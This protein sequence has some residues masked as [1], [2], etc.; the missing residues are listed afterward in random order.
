MSLL[1]VIFGIAAH[2]FSLIRSFGILV[3][4]ASALDA[5]P[6]CVSPPHLTSKHGNFQSHAGLT[7]LNTLCSL[8]GTSVRACE[9]AGWVRASLPS[10]SVSSPKV[11]WTAQNA[12]PQDLET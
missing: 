3:L 7:L 4:S 1:N 9:L 5:P 2:Q 8:R 12:H 6:S 11:N 10:L